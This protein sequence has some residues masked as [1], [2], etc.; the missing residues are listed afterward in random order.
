MRILMCDHMLR[1][2][3]FLVARDTMSPEAF[4]KV[5]LSLLEYRVE[6]AKRLYDDWGRMFKKWPCEVSW[7]RAPGAREAIRAKYPEVVLRN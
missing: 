1:T 4:G 2:R 5:A 3:E 6:I 7:W